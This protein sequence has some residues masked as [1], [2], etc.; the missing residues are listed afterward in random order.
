MD[1]YTKYHYQ[2]QLPS[3]T[4]PPFSLAPIATTTHKPIPSYLST[5]SPPLKKQS[6][7]SVYST[8]S[9]T[10]ILS[11]PKTLS[12]KAYMSSILVMVINSPPSPPSHASA[13][14]TKHYYSVTIALHH[15]RPATTQ[16]IARPAPLTAILSDQ[17]LLPTRCSVE[18]AI[19]AQATVKLVPAYTLVKFAIL[20]IS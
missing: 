11:M 1:V 5:I 8:T 3:A 12:G 19:N 17:T 16:V 14:T 18:D 15:A 20:V 10:P 4:T 13:T 6:I 9:P 2:G 7:N